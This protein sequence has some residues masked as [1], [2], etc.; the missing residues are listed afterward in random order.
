MNRIKLIGI[1]VACTVVIL[2]G[3]MAVVGC[4]TSPSA[5]NAASPGFLKIGETYYG[6][7]VDGWEQRFKVLEIIDD[8]WIV[9]E[10]S[11]EGETMAVLLN[12]TQLIMIHQAP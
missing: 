9:A 10:L 7:F 2:V 6:Y 3:I 11:A 1:V 8:R 12:V 5:A 4:D